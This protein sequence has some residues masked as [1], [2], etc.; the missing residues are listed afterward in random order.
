MTQVLTS[1]LA[2]ADWLRARVTGALQCDSRRLQPGVP[3][4]V[5]LR[6]AV[7]CRW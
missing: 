4:V 7:S 5:A 1:P 3:L 2:V 6:S